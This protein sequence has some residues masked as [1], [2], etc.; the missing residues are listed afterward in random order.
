VKNEYSRFKVVGV[1]GGGCRIA[2]VIAYENLRNIEVVAVDT[3]QE[4][5]DK[6]PFIHNKIALGARALGAGGDPLV[7]RQV[8]KDNSPTLYQAMGGASRVMLIAAMGGGTGTG[9]LPIMFDIADTLG[10]YGIALVTRPFS[11]EGEIRQRIANEAIR[12]F[13]DEKKTMFV[14]SNDAMLPF[15]PLQPSIDEAFSIAARSAA[16]QVL[17]RI[18]QTT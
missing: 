15:L 6:L 18:V 4:A 16:W 3:C 17:S 1:G 11:F 14:K 5:L 2:E 9:A 7:G 13:Q 12:Q 10:V 8:A